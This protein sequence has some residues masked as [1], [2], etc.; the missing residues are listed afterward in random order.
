MRRL[1]FEDEIGVVHDDLAEECGT[2][3]EVQVQLALADA[4]A[5]DH[6]VETR[7]GDAALA[8]QRCGGS[9]DPFAGR[10]PLS[11]SAARPFH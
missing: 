10:A 2:A 9:D 1:G 5:L 8:D 7:L 11:P 4:S 6:V 3:G